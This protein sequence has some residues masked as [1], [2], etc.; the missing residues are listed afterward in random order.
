MVHVGSQSPPE[1]AFPKPPY[2]ED[3]KIEEGVVCWLCNS[4]QAYKWTSLIDH[5]RNKHKLTHGSLQGTYLHEQARAELREKDRERY[6]K[7]R[8]AKVIKI[9]NKEQESGTS[10]Q[11]PKSKKQRQ[12]VQGSHD[13][14]TQ[15][16]IPQPA[17]PPEFTGGP[18]LFKGSDGSKWRAMLC[19]IL[20]NGE[21]AT[22]IQVAPLPQ[23]GAVDGV[24]Q[25]A[26]RRGKMEE[27]LEKVLSSPCPQR[28]Q[29]PTCPKVTLDSIL[30]SWCHPTNTDSRQSCPLPAPE[31][32]CDLT[33]FKGFLNRIHF[34]ERTKKMYL[35]GLCR[36]LGLLHT[37][38]KEYSPIGL[39][40]T[41]YKDG[42][43]EKIMETPVM[44]IKYGWTIK[45]VQAVDHWVTF[46]M[47]ECNKHRY[48]E[49]RTTLQQLKDEL[50]VF[51]KKDGTYFRK[52]ANRAK[53]IVDAAKLEDFTEVVELKKSVKKAM[54][55]LA[56]IVNTSKGQESLSGSLRAAATTALIGIVHFNSYAGRSGE[57]ETMPKEHAQE[58][59]MKKADHLLCMQHKTVDSHGVLAKY[60]P[61]GSMKAVEAYLSLPGHTSPLLFQP[62]TRQAKH[63]PVACYL[64]RFGAMYLG[65]K[66]PNSNLIRKWFHT[67]L[68]EMSW[69]AKALGLLEQVD[70]HSTTTAKKVYVVKTPKQ[71]ARL[72]KILY[73]ALMGS[74]EE[75]PS[76]EEIY[77][78]Q[79][80]QQDMMIVLVNAQE[81][82]DLDE[83]QQQQEPD[84]DLLLWDC[85]V[86]DTKLKAPQKKDKID[87]DDKTGK[88]DIED[89][90]HKE[91]KQDKKTKGG[92]PEA[93]SSQAVQAGGQSS[94]PEYLFDTVH[95]GRPSPF[96]GAV[97][98]WLAERVKGKTCDVQLSKELL[99][100]GRKE[101]ILDP[102]TN[103]EQVRSCIKR[104]R[105]HGLA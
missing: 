50:I 19:K 99:E 78:L 22:P 56:C 44:D 8:H 90:M 27:L 48:T 7:K 57:W 23:A 1:A 98:A 67:K 16:A 96:T 32:S 5:C 77:Q 62:A 63:I 88:Q 75:W 24:A 84:E 103:F 64:R 93:G 6:T 2:T 65:G 60:M 43:L 91:E 101:G 17:P 20:D 3:T 40:C 68:V 41:L 70:A 74:P 76:D 73:E 55:D 86:K 69:E 61:P 94:Q 38:A 66:C 34:K 30:D 52:G 80:L 53:M 81:A 4:F 104:M 82:H 18:E 95:R 85:D 105:E 51:Y 28:Q 15:H 58:Q 39:L 102:L 46:L 35:K 9:E 92:K 13:T 100:Q 71:D 59:I 89:N 54:L 72:G 83:M 33:G 37:D 21:L 26:G 97:K 12:H 10:E 42:L 25:Q 36:F 14:A 49:S 45:I 79:Q 31:P 87:K 29:E 47:T 11:S